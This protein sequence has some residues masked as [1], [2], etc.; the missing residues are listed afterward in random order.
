MPTLDKDLWRRCY[1]YVTIGEE[2]I[3]D[4]T[5]IMLPLELKTRAS[6]QAKK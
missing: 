1:A 6:N 4:R 3:M 5:T 2:K